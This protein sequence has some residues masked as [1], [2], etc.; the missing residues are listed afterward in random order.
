MKNSQHN[1]SATSTKKPV[2]IAIAC[3]ALIATAIFYFSRSHSDESKKPAEVDSPMVTLQGDK[4]FIPVNSPLRNRLLLAPVATATPTHS[5]AIPAVV[6][7]NPATTV[8]ILAPLTGKLTEIKVKLGDDV[9]AGQVLAVLNSSDLA[10]AYADAAKARD[11]L[12]LA[13]RALDRGLGVNSAG[14]NATKDLEQI[15]SSYNQALAESVRAQARLKTLGAVDEANPNVAGKNHLLTITAPISGTITAMNSGAGSFQNDLTATIMTIAN[16][17][18]VWVTA[19]VPEN[20]VASVHKGQLADVTLDAYPGQTWQGK[21]AF[22]SAVLEQD[23][24]RNKA[25]I[26]FKNVGGHLKPNM[27]AVVKLA[28]AETG[29]LM[30]PTS[31]L[32]MNND[33]ITV[34]VETAPWTFVRRRV[35]IGSEDG[36]HVS[37]L[38]G[39]NAN[40]RIIVSGGVLIND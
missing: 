25:R 31:A 7:A 11:A 3:V 14:A 5:I 6:E 33:S 40:E 1:T 37:V 39:L 34:F 35:S 23:T 28:T 15:E 26:S 20:L 18:N 19:N 24:H 17:D 30:I 36:D 16:L 4:L 32:L 21:I 2:V 9:K 22:V 29:K 38:S 27:Y 13:K 12:D 8:N 10:Q